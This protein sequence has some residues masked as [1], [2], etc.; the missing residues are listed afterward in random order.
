MPLQ[1]AF[2]FSFPVVFGDDYKWSDGKVGLTFLSVIVGLSIALLVTPRLEANYAKRA[3]AKGGNA[4]PE[5]RLR[6]ARFPP[7]G[8]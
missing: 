5:V 7:S 8:S 6:C 1:Y 2:F 4:D 3:A